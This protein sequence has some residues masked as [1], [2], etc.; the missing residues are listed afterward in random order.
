[1][2]ILEALIESAILVD[3]QSRDK[4][5]TIEEMAAPLAGIANIKPEKLVKIL[6]DREQ[7]GST[8]IGSGIAIPHGKL[9]GLD[10]LL[11][12]FGLSRAGIDFNSIDNQPAHIFFLLITPEN[13]SV[14]HLKMLAHISSI[15]RNEFFRH[16][17]IKARNRTDVLTML[18]KEEDSI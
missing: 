18:K 9:Q 8:G 5:G 6:T 4:K 1:M 14:T 15:C 7:L 12:G 11:L 16:E 2:K 10:K 13:A 17:I 3:L